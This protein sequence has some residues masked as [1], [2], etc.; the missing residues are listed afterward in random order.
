MGKWA[1]S[2]MQYGGY[3]TLRRGEKITSGPRS[4][5]SGGMAASPLPYGGS[6]TL[7]SG[8]QNQKWPSTEEIGYIA[9]AAWVV[10]KTLET[11]KKHEMAH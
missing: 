10:P 6:T 7:H 5:T 8:G 2:L 9:L 1:T 3:P 11:H 4:P